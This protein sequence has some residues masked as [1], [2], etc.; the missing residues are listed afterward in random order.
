[1]LF[2]AANQMHN[3]CL[4]ADQAGCDILGQPELAL[5]YYIFNRILRIIGMY[6]HDLNMVPSNTQYHQCGKGKKR[7]LRFSKSGDK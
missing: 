7:A 3:L 1:M 5:I 4:H 6:V 2:G